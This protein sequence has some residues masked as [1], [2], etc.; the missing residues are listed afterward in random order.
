MLHS[1]PDTHKQDL[2]VWEGGQLSDDL[3]TSVRYR[4]KRKEILLAAS[5]LAWVPLRD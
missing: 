4:M 2:E 3:A 1:Y 5:G